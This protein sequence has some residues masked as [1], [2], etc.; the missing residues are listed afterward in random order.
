ML[1]EKQIISDLLNLEGPVWK[2]IMRMAP[3][4]KE[5]RTLYRPYF[6]NTPSSAFHFALFVD[7]YPRKDT[8]KVACEDP[9]HAI[10]Y[11]KEIDKKP[12]PETW[13]SVEGTDY[14]D[15]YKKWVV[16]RL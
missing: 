16:Y 8:R 7:R 12:R 11:A 14:E 3:A 6:L 4:L 1:S 10:W 9:Q 13:E 5:N 2:Y 15:S